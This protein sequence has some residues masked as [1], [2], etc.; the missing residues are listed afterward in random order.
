L[1]ATFNFDLLLLRLSFLPGAPARGGPLL[2]ERRRHNLVGLATNARFCLRFLDLSL[3]LTPLPKMSASDVSPVRRKSFRRILM[4]LVK[5]LFVLVAAIL[6]VIVAYHA[7]VL[8]ADG[9]APIPIPTRVQV[10]DGGAPIPIP[11]NTLAADGGAPIPIPTL[12][13]DG[14]A[15]IP[16]PHIL[17]ADGGAPIPIPHST[18]SADGGAPI[19]IPTHNVTLIAA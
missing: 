7:A 11:T 10:A 8:S 19:P 1:Y 5:T 3:T 9:G 13:A 14:G 12:A 17:V 4:R 18:L 16:I 6:L 2:C 15:P